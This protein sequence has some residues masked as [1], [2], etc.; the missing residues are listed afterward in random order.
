MPQ[1]LEKDTSVRFP[2][3]TVLK[4]SAG[5]GKTYTLTQR[6]VQFL[7]SEKIPKNRLRNILAITFSNN[8]A[9]EMKERTLAWLKEIH[10]GDEEKVAALSEILSLT[11]GKWLEDATE[12]IEVEE[13]KARAGQLIDEILE[14]YVDF[15]VKTIDSFMTTVFKASA[16]DFGYNPDF[17]ILMDNT[18]L[19][20]YSFNLFLRNVKQGTAEAAY[21]ESIVDSLLEYKKQDGAYLWIPS[22]VLLDETKK[23]YSKLSATGKEAETEDYG[24]D[25]EK[26]KRRITSCVE[27][28]EEEIERSGLKRHGASA[29]KS[30]PQ[31]IREKTFQELVGKAYATPPVTK[32]S[33]GKADEQAAYDRIAALW[34][35]FKTLA[36]ELTVIFC[37]SSYTPYVK[38]FQA[39][40]RIVDITKKQ[41]GKIF[42]G[43]IN[44][45]L[46]E[47]L[48][49]AIVPDVYFRIGEVIFHF[50]IDEFQDTSPIQWRNL[51]PLIENSLAQGGSLFVV[52]DT[53]Q[54]I[55]GFRNADYTIMKALEGSNPFPSAEHS[56]K[57][58]DTNYRSKRKIL[59]FNE[60]IFKTKLAE[61]A[62]YQLAGGKSGL[63]DYI[64][65]PKDKDENDG[66]VELSLLEKKEEEPAEREKI[67]ELIEGLR[68]RGYG[69]RDIAIL[70]QTNEHAVRVTSWLNEKAVPFIS[71][72]SLDIRRRKIT[73]EIMALINF[74]DSPT[75]D[76]SFGEFI[77]GDIFNK[78]LRADHPELSIEH[79]REFCFTQRRNPPLYKAFQ[80]KFRGLWEKYFDGLFRVSGFLPIYD[81]MTELFAV[82]RVFEKM[83]KEEAALIKFLEVVKEF[84]S[85]GSNSL[86][87]F[88]ATASDEETGDADWDMAV[89]KN[90]EA[91]KIMT[92]HKSKG[93]GFPVV[94]VLLYEVRNRGFDYIVEEKGQTV[95]MLKIKKEEAECDEI[96]RGLYDAEKMR[97]MV[98]RLNTLYVGFTRPQRELYV[99]GVKN[100]REGYPFLLLPVEEYPPSEKPEYHPPDLQATA[101]IDNCPLHHRFKQLEFPSG[102]EEFISVEERKRGDFIHRVL[103]FI[104]D[105]KG[106]FET[107]LLEIIKRVKEETGSD[108]SDAP[109][110]D[111]IL[112]IVN[113]KEIGGY[114]KT[115]P[116]REIRKEQ[117]YSDGSGNLFRMDRVVIDPGNLMVI[118]YKTGKSKGALEKYQ[119]QLRNYMSIL[120]DIYQDKVI[121]GLIAFVD[122]NEVEK[123]L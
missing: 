22:T 31:K 80:E 105:V 92:I 86:T 47:Y 108:Y 64:Q 97:E 1:I 73:G 121:T 123:V 21:L 13:M 56:V 39:F 14:N 10:F 102:H 6:M 111:L 112:A 2:H 4:A 20:E 58:L 25:L 78:T 16:I 50:L 94:I 81:L 91:V 122:L 35:E 26:L 38:T 66:Y 69:Y 117:E 99:V 62:E 15:Q 37:R 100:K 93:L 18:S 68:S 55:Y 106:D 30:I 45:Y 40:T 87:D 84:E 49:S 12:T 104:D 83:P 113:N 8:A 23:I 120:R 107:R 29:Y 119:A 110:K 88:L 51:F 43:D 5:S 90:I 42:I 54:S 63:T 59:E 48:N 103:F 17:D 44:S 24:E 101:L 76:F 115:A 7:L 79:L 70:T 89:P 116:G 19:M 9:K 67:Q 3:L 65:K 60:H 61:N 53:K 34:E 28:I 114:F 27:K 71:Y 118:D 36:W 96:L 74:L 11:S 98:N 109:I 95:H 32:P 33:K 75:D 82:F 41:Q 57:E 46:A 77:L 72:S 85:E 52:G